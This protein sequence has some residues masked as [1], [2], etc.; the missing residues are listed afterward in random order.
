M[1]VYF[2]V[3]LMLAVLN[4]GTVFGA[5]LLSE[6]SK[7][8]CFNDIVIS[9]LCVLALYLLILFNANL[10]VGGTYSFYVMAI[11]SLVFSFNAFVKRNRVFLKEDLSSLAEILIIQAIAIIFLFSVYDG[12]KFWAQEGPNHDSLVYFEGMKW[13]LDNSLWVAKKIVDEKWRLGVCDDS[14]I[15]I[16]FDCVLYRGGT[17][18]LSAWL[19]L[20]NESKTPQ[21]LFCLF[22]FVGVISFYATKLL[23]IKIRGKENSI[24]TVGFSILLLFSTA[25]LSA[26]FNSNLASLLAAGTLSLIV[27]ILIY[28][29]LPIIAKG[30]LLGLWTA[31]VVHI[32]AEAIFYCALIFAIYIV[33]D[34][35]QRKESNH[36]KNVVIGVIVFFTT[37]FVF[38]NV[39]LISAF[40]SL[41]AFKS[42]AQGGQ[43]QAYYLNAPVW[44]WGGAFV[45]GELMGGQL[46]S[47]FMSLCGVFITIA[48]FIIL[49]TKRMYLAPLLALVGTSFFA[50]LVIEYRSYQYGE[51][52]I[53]Q[54]LGM[55]WVVFAI[56]AIN[57]VLIKRFSLV[58]GY[59]RHAYSVY[60]I[61]G[62]G[63]LLSLLHLNQN[64]SRQGAY[65]LESNA[66]SHG[67]YWG[68]DDFLLRI[69][70]KEIVLIDDSSWHGIEKF[71]KSHYLTFLIH[72]RG[73]K[74]VMPQF[75]EGSFS[76]GY[77][78]NKLNNGFVHSEVPSWYLRGTSDKNIKTLFEITN[79][80]PTFE[81]EKRDFSLT[82]I[83]SVTSFA[84]PAKGWYEREAEHCW[85]DG[86]FEIQAFSSEDVSEL[87]VEMDFFQP[88]ANAGLYIEV[89]GQLVGNFDSSERIF[90]VPLKK[91]MNIVKITPGWV[92]ASPAERGLSLD[93]RKLFAAVR[94]VA[95]ISQ[96]EFK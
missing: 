55:S 26:L 3:F 79:P 43:W 78:R 14:S 71:H 37:L 18:T 12:Q 54:L 42:I 8:R 47:I 13:S 53:I 84:L 2:Y 39:V 57:E 7:C 10:V 70:A 44:M 86:V 80:G 72:E 95:V 49:G 93:A 11:L 22:A 30:F 64:F 62:V 32:Y 16:G 68:V 73:A 89:N 1:V 6:K 82:K 50:V 91:G 9:Q 81:T 66:A 34:S 58:R 45:V 65:L 19:Q 38:S 94:N 63:I 25:P 96:T 90:K 75:T 51:H 23:Q 56:A 15:W 33:I 48:L 36:L 31:V 35:L 52:K 20:L 76:G 77:F 5:R 92:P 4:A 24:A 83:L 28:E 61:A 41:F 46:P 17:Y 27:A 21:G 74:A 40:Q 59:D 60:P 87:K 67:I 85:T 88:P 69:Q 29:R